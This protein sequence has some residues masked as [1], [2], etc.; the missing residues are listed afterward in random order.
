MKFRRFIALFLIL[1]LA[2]P[3]ACAEEDNESLK[4]AVLDWINQAAQDA[5]KWADDA[6]KTAS[7]WLTQAWGD[8]SKWVS[9]AWNHTS[10]WAVDIWGDASTWAKGV[11]DSASGAVS[12]WL[13]ETFDQVTKNGA[14]TWEWIQ[15][16]SKETRDQ[17]AEK[18][19]DISAIAR[20]GAAEA[21]QQIRAAYEKVL[22]SMGLNDEDVGKVW[23]TIRAY[24]AEKGITIASIQKI[25]FPYLV[26]L[27]MESLKQGT[28]VI[29][30][31]TVAQFLTAVI[32][33]Q[34][35]K[36]EEQAQDLLDNLDGVLNQ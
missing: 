16:E 26:K 18:Y 32:E 17:I 15:N 1:C 22:K 36:T 4:D 3:A 12:T 29:P 2:V 33:K 35:V 6:W 20:E 23:E 24:A 19:H 8:A 27:A 25:M 34:N 7:E 9:Q 10:G 14:D 31:I 30:A 28:P 11:Y 5:S 21:E 13:V